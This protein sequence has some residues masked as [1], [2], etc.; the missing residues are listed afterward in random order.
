MTSSDYEPVV[1]HERELEELRAYFV[2]AHW[3]FLRSD[4]QKELEDF[5]DFI[6]DES[7]VWT[8]IN[9]SANT[10]FISINK[11]VEI[12]RQKFGLEHIQ[13]LLQRFIIDDNNRKRLYT[14]GIDKLTMSER[15]VFRSK[16]KILRYFLSFENLYKEKNWQAE[17]EEDN[18]SE[19]WLDSLWEWIWLSPQPAKL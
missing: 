4:I 17:G 18:K 9:V 15:D 7:E 14:M 2:S 6:L 19:V 1:W 11:F 12:Y 5:E 10:M 16:S 13:T 8:Q 3:E